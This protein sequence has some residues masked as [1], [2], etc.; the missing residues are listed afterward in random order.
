MKK[1]FRKRKKIVEK[2]ATEVVEKIK[3]DV[4]EDPAHHWIPK[5]TKLKENPFDTV[6]PKKDF[7]PVKR[8]SRNRCD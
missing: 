7:V 1:A 6:T 4:E 5:L 8:P 3:N 2:I